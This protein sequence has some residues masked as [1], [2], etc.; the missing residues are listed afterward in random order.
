[1]SVKARSSLPAGS[2]ST[3]I[4]AA[5]A[6]AREA[7]KLHFRDPVRYVYNPLTYASAPHEAYLRKFAASRKRVIFLGMNPGPWGMAQTGVPFG[8]VA[9][10]RDW[11]GIA[12]KVEQPPRGHARLSVQGFACTRSEV[13][14]RRL[15]G[16]M[17][18]RYGTAEAFSRDAFVSNY[19]PLLF[20]DTE[21]RNITPDRIHRDDRG[22]LHA[23]CDRFL[24]TVIRTLLPDWLV[25]VG[26]FAERRAGAALSSPSGLGTRVISITHPS[27]AN[28]RANRGW[29]SQAKE[30]LSA[31]GVW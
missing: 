23:V 18:Q 19:C 29:A 13:S 11:L 30:T 6:L 31:H 7:G 26:A 15:W 4:K 5:R 27:P 12:G 24:A 2:I 16:L 1:M 21:G 20:L 25:A 14:G 17:R 28:P 10:V 9:T 3:L 22:P 8:E